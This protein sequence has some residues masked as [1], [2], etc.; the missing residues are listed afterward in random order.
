MA[1]CAM[2]LRRSVVFIRGKPRACPQKEE[3]DGGLSSRLLS[4]TVY[5]GS[6]CARTSVMSG[7]SVLP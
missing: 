6:A 3:E 5:E 4:L 7:R 2:H 1:P